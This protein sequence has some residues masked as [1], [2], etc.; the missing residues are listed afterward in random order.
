MEKIINLQ[1]RIDLHTHSTASDGS[2]TPE[3]L[4][5]KAFDLGIS[6]IS[7]TD[8]DSISGLDSAIE[9]SKEFGI[10][11]ITGVELSVNHE[12]GSLHL[13]GFGFDHR[14]PDLVSTI[15]KLLNSRCDRN[16]KMIVRLQDLGYFIERGDVEKL[17]DGGSVTR[18]HIAHA[19]IK[20]GY[21]SDIKEVFR[22]LLDR[23]APAY[24]NRYRLGL[25]EAISLIHSA[26]GVAVWAHPG[27]H[28]DNL[29]ELLSRLP[30]W[31]EY[32][33]DGIEADYSQHSI[34]LRDKLRSL[35]LENGMIYTGGSDFHGRLKPDIQLAQGP[36]NVEIN[37]DCSVMLKDRVDEVRSGVEV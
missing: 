19:L 3:E 22:E 7:I 9:A 10:E 36:E 20:T 29:P 15:C 21:F 14:N 24:I 8:H 12:N 32:G 25:E 17:S 23:G 2:L 13:L 1:H 31:V 11:F 33:L 27:L 30:Q 4:V 6:F 16:E 34:L 18:G 28:V 26:G 37:V 35:A 5:E